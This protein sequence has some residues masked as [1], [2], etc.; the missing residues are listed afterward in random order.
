MLR[1]VGRYVYRLALTNNRLLSIDDG[2]GRCRDQDSQLHRWKTMALPA[3]E[4]IRRF[5]P[6]VLPQGFHTVRYYGLWSPANRTRLPRV[7]LGLAGPTPTPYPAAPE[8]AT[9]LDDSCPPPLRV[10]Q[11]CPPCGHGIL[12]LIRTM[13]RLQRGP[14]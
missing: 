4:C 12:V 14:P 2:Q 9:C 6:H 13:P 3:H 11:T 1:D 10:G 5:R 7:Q 8:P